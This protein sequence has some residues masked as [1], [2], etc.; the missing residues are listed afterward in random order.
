MRDEDDL[1]MLLD[2]KIKAG[3]ENPDH[4]SILVS[5]PYMV[6]VQGTSKDIPVVN[7]SYISSTQYTILIQQSLQKLEYGYY[8]KAEF[9][10]LDLYIL[11]HYAQ[12]I[13][14][15][16]LHRAFYPN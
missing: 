3:F 9:R 11:L 14:S 8:T 13:D 1:V 6:E 16:L 12:V 2:Q 7:E 10:N 15:C 4:I 5:K